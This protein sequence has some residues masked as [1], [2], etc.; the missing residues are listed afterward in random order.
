MKPF[1][2]KILLFLTGATTFTI[3]NYSFDFLLYPFALYQLGVI[4][5]FSVMVVLSFL[6]CWFYFLIYDY[7]K[8]D[9]LGI[10]F[11][12]DKMNSIITSNNS[13]GYKLLLVKILRKSHLFLFVFLSIYFNP[14][15]AVAF[16]R[17]GNLEYNG[18]SAHDW[19]MFILSV[20]ISN[21]FWAS[22][23]F[24]GLSFFEFLFKLI[25]QWWNM[26]G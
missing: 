6:F 10:E 13:K 9:F 5:G 15:V 7:L 1:I 26:L 18:L 20:I 3:I 21:G 16:R 2:H 11:S 25:S 12:K 8:R 14:F 23:V 17:K 19:R 22:T 4:Y 24:V